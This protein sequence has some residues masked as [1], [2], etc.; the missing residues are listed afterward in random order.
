MHD[1]F[2]FTLVI[3]GWAWRLPGLEQNHDETFHV[4]DDKH[5]LFDK[6]FSFPFPERTP[7]MS[8]STPSSSSPPAVAF[9][10]SPSTS[11]SSSSSSYGDGN[12]FQAD[13]KKQK[14]SSDRRQCQ[15]FQVQIQ[16]SFSHTKI[17]QIA[18]F[19]L[20]LLLLRPVPPTH[21]ISSPSIHSRWSSA[22]SCPTT[23]R[24]S[25]TRWDTGTCG[26]P[27]TTS[28]SSSGCPLINLIQFVLFRHIFRVFFLPFL[29]SAKW[30]YETGDKLPFPTTH[31]HIAGSNLCVGGREGRRSAISYLLLH[32]LAVDCWL[33]FFPNA[34]CSR[35]GEISSL[36]PSV[37]M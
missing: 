35:K 32:R 22:V 4:A 23:S 30:P 17:W 18:L 14:A 13:G 7:S 9:D 25:P 29:S 31:P 8:E 2:L 3:T 27:N 10:H 1:F 16:F 12:S 5:L 28:R 36:P 24:P 34:L 15:P 11:F 6:H 26:R 20:L 37:P 33:L 21:P 19:L